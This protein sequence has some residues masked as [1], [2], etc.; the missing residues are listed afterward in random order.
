MMYKEHYEGSFYDTFCGSIEDIKSGPKEDLIPV[1]VPKED[2]ISGD[3]YIVEN[4]STVKY[5]GQ[6]SY[7]VIKRT[8]L[9]TNDSINNL[10]ENQ[11]KT[12]WILTIKCKNGTGEE[13]EEQYK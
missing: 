9:Y 5:M 2:L 13:L 10:D 3:L 11:I 8:P 12:F 7:E 4:G 1:K 6:N